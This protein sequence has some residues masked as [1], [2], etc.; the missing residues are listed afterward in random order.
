MATATG[1][2]RQ[3]EGVMELRVLGTY[4]MESRETRF[5]SHLIDGVLALDAGSLTRAL[6]FEE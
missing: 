6:S 5:E 4:N 1:V 3:D 2:A